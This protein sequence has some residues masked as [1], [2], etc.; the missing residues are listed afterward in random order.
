N[1]DP[2]SYLLKHSPEALEKL[3]YPQ[4]ISASSAIHRQ[5]SSF[6]RKPVE[7][8][9][10]IE[11]NQRR[12]LIRGIE[13]SPNKLKANLRAENHRK[14]HIDTV[15]LYNAKARAQFIKD[16]TILFKEEQEVVEQD[17]Q[18]II[19]A[20]EEH[21]AA[22]KDDADK[23]IV[24]MR[25]EERRQAISFGK[26]S[27]LIETIL[28]DIALCGF[29]GE[30]MNKLVAYLAMTSRKMENPLSILIISGSGAGKT[31]LQDAVLSLC[32]EEELIKLTSLT[33]KALFYKK[34]LSLTHRVLAVEEEKGAEEADYAI[35]N[36]ITAKELVIEATIKD[37]YTGKLTTMTNTVKCNTA[38]FKT[39]TNP[40]SNPE[41]KTRFII[42]SVDES[43]A[44]TQRILEYQRESETPQGYLKKL[45][46]DLITTK[47][48]NFQRLLKPI[49]VLN[50]Y[51][52]LLTYLDD[53][54]S[55]RRDHP[56]YLQLIKAIA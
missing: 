6:N 34:E 20:V 18:R 2:N 45:E 38:V 56:K 4:K 53:R 37:V 19:L 32:P 7:D 24:T 35:R 9:F 54:M 49:T 17:M 40:E 13:G 55:V 30:D 44:Q 16:A 42:L 12:Y 21:I 52:K 29:I 25:D 26:Q 3:I 28:K 47:H 46:R 22:K 43:R 14:F 11:H 33:G 27:N 15:D 36:L 1:E 23:P 48:R 39:T 5:A 31:S 50:P 8:G 10:M 41:T 51:A